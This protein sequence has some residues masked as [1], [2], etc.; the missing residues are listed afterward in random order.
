ML[1][2]RPYLYLWNDGG[3]CFLLIIYYYIK[4]IKY[5]T[6]GRIAQVKKSR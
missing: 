2:E 5:P 4:I 1:L 6:S 3:A